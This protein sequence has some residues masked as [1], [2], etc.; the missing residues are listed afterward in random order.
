MCGAEAEQKVPVG[1]LGAVLPAHHVGAHLLECV[2]GRDRVPPRGVHLASLL[3]E[4]L[5]VAEHALVRRTP[6]EHD[7]HE[8][9]RIEPEPDLLTHLRDPVGGEP[10]LPVLVVGQVRLRQPAGRTGRV[11]LGHP[12]L[13]LPAQRRER[14]DARIEPDVAD[15]R[16]PGDRLTAGGAPDRHAVDPRPAQLLELFEALRRALP[17]LRLRAEHGQVA[18][19][20]R[21][22]RQR[23]P[24]VAAPR[25][26]PVAHVAQ[27]VVHPLAHVL[28][29]P[30]PPSRSLRA[31][32]PRI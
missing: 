30:T 9:L 23:Q 2:L 6:D 4:H 28:R 24:V 11:A 31:A 18:A 26:V 5:L 21:I 3:V 27:P 32:A 17:Q 16:D 20:A 1:R 25:D 12:F 22:E 19:R 7:R 10:A 29:A 13:V 14:N 8:E 15:L